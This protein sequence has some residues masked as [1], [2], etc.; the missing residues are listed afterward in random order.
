M[1]TYRTIRPAPTFIEPNWPAPKH[2]KAFTSMRVGG[3]SKSPYDTFNLAT[4]VND[5]PV[6]VRANRRILYGNLNLPSEPLW[7]NQVHGIAVAEFIDENN[8]KPIPADASVAFK[9]YQVCVVLTADCLPL[10]VCNKAGSKVSAIHAGWKGLAAGVIEAT[11]E[12]MYCKPEDLLVW[13]G[14]AIGPDSFEVGEEVLKNFG[15][16]K[17]QLS[18]SGFRPISS[19]KYLADIYHLAR[20]RLNRIGVDNQAIFGGDRCTFIEKELFYSYR[21][22]KE[23]GR[24]ASLIWINPH[25]PAGTFSQRE[26]DPTI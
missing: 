24:M 14:P 15:A 2:I 23:T 21:R 12:K 25:P 4:H 7:L 19:G 1:D 22:D 6:A 3:S 16:K 11:I 5:D 8:Q 10:L 18:D 13:L 17:D 26:K 20:Q 9:P